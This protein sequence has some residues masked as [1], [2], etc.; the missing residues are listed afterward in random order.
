[1]GHVSVKYIICEGRSKTS[2]P[3][4]ERTHIVEHFYC[5]NKLSLLIKLEKII[6]ISVIISVQLRPV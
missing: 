1:M 4:Q 3:H 2:K 6:H 5:G